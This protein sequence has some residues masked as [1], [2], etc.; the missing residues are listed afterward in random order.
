MAFKNDHVECTV[1]IAADQMHVRASGVV[2]VP[3]AYTHMT[4]IAPNSVDRLTSYS[5]SGLP[6]PCANIAFENTPNKVVI[7]PTGVFDVTFTYPNSYYSNNMLQ[8]IEPS[9]FFILQRGPTEE[10]VYV[11][12]PLE[13]VL[14]LRTLTHRPERTGP[15][16]YSRVEDLIAPTT[17]EGVMRSLKEYKAKY[18]IA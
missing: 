15:E 8:R 6:F 2:R 5:G 17:A 7:D 10:A 4:V 14:P 3:S 13:D 9:L 11:R 1:V 12:I 16:F 18:G